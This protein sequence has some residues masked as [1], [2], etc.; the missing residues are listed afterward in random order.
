MSETNN[1]RLLM[2]KMENANYEGQ[3]EIQD[4]KDKI[5]RRNMLATDLRKQIVDKDQQI[6]DLKAEKEKLRAELYV[7][8]GC[9]KSFNA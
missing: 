2:E 6:K 3:A 1:I 5:H 8:K 7:V 9:P 4:L